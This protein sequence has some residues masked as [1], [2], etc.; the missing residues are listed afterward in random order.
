MTIAQ[1][2]LSN[3]DFLRRIDMM[4]MLVVAAALTV[5]PVAHAVGPVIALA[6]VSVTTG[7][8]SMQGDSFYAVISADGRY[9]AFDSA[10]NT[11]VP[12]TIQPA[13]GQGVA[14]SGD[15]PINVYLRDRVAGTTELVSIGLGGTAPNNF[16]YSPSI[17]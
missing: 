10:S 8:G 7:G 14:S 1:Q 4:R 16:S 5:V 12:G 6:R 13:A 9:V 17:S 11:L 2:H 3:T 15:Y